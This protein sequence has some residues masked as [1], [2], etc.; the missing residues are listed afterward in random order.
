MFIY[1]AEMYCDSCGDAIKRI[2]IAEGNGPEDPSDEMSFDSDNFPKGP[3]PEVKT[4]TPD[5]CA[6]RE[7][8]LE[9]IDLAEYGL[10]P[11]D[12]LFG[13]EATHI[14]ANLSSGLYDVSYLTELLEEDNPTPFQC[15]LFR[16]WRELFAEELASV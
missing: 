13:A 8:C 10:K 15:A 4:A 3:L 12:E 11:G 16:L 14:G 2:L 6:S 5:H 7:A 1:Q 9:P